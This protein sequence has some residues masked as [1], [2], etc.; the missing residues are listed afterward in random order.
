MLHLVT[1]HLESRCSQYRVKERTSNIVLHKKAMLNKGNIYEG[2]QG[3][4]QESTPVYIQIPFTPYGTN[5]RL[6]ATT[7]DFGSKEL[8]LRP[9][10]LWCVRGRRKP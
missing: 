4:P 7:R 10:F 8:L 3:M 2:N 6:G 1:H 5:L 9:T